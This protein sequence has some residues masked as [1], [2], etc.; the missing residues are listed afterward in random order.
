[1]NFNK[2]FLLSFIFLSSCTNTNQ[3]LQSNFISSSQKDPALSGDGST[4][5]FIQEKNGRPTIRLENV[6]TGK[7]VYLRHIIKNHPHSSPSLSWN[8]RYIAVI[9]QS[10]RKP[11]VMIED[12][13]KRR[14]YKLILPGE[15]LPISLSISPDASKIAVQFIKQGKSQIQ[16]F[17][18]RKILEEDIVNKFKLL[19]NI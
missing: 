10:T 15:Y 6:L 2:I 19:N 4:L 11:I 14:L 16:I 5:A 1:M 12:L 3:R 9:A 7:P 13:R 8:A 17:S 18:L